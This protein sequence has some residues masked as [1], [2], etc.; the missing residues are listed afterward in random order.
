MP[1]TSMY[2]NPPMIYED[3]L[4]K[5]EVRYAEVIGSL[6]HR[7]SSLIS[8]FRASG[9]LFEH[10][11]RQSDTIREE[12]SRSR[13]VENPFGDRQLQE[14]SD[15]IGKWPMIP[16]RD[17][18]MKIYH[19]GKVRGGIDTCI[20]RCPYIGATIDRDLK[21]EGSKLFQRCFPDNELLRDAIS[22]Q[23]ETSTS[24]AAEDEHFIRFGEGSRAL[25]SNI[26]DGNVYSTTWKGRVFSCEISEETVG[27]LILIQDAYYGAFKPVE[28]DTQQR[29]MEGR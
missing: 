8:E 18:A 13:T 9:H 17:C 28:A 29:Y 6:L 7:M 15:I 3:A 22:H 4:P 26:L 2:K 23:E 11:V 27:K 20:A 21:R 14:K 19:F 5:E 25:F 24:I 1:V 12:F 10:C 16:A